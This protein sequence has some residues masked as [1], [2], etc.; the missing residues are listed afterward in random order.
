MILTVLTQRVLVLLCAALRCPTSCLWFLWTCSQIEPVCATQPQCSPV[1]AGDCGDTGA[2]RCCRL[3]RYVSYY[4]Q[5]L[6][7]Q[8]PG[9]T[10]IYGECDFR[11]ADVR[12]RIGSLATSLSITVN[13][14]NFWLRCWSRSRIQ[15]FSTMTHPCCSNW[16]PSA[17][18]AGSPGRTAAGF[19]PG[20]FDASTE[21]AAT[22]NHLL[23]SAGLTGCPY[24]MTSYCEDD[25][26]SADYA[27]GVQVLPSSVP[28]ECGC[29]G[30]G[31]VAT[32][33]GPSGHPTRCVAIAEGRRADVFEPDGAASPSHCT[34]CWWRSSNPYSAG[35]SSLRER[36]T[37]LR[38]CPACFGLQLRWQLWAFG[39]PRLA[40][41]VP[42][43]IL[44]S[45]A[46]TAR[47]FPC[48]IRGRPVSG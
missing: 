28:G 38:R 47:V 21:P 7:T 9:V 29:A 14:A 30:V 15:Y 37:M 43:Q 34:T 10:G 18:G 40:Q 26:A 19:V 44:Y 36:W 17:A 3:F 31:W 32:C 16:L 8:P 5:V 1:S 4:E 13:A 41:E 11:V 12:R 42:G 23:I 20:G 33:H 25:I 48:V 39:I 35:S 27:F 45:R 46:R 6:A 24:R 22:S 2:R